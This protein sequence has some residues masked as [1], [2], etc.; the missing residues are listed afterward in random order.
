MR[1]NRKAFFDGY[2]SG[3]RHVFPRSAFPDAVDR[4][5]ADAVLSPQLRKARALSECDQD[6]LD[7]GNGERSGVYPLAPRRSLGM[8]IA[9]I[10]STSTRAAFSGHVPCVVEQRAN[11]Q[12]IRSHARR[13]IAMVTGRHARRDGI[14]L[15]HFPRNTVSVASSS[16]VLDAAV[17]VFVTVRRPDPARPKLGA[18]DWPVLIDLIPETIR[19]WYFRFSQDVNLLRLGFVLVRLDQALTRL[20]GPFAFYHRAYV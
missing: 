7:V 1:F 11:E 4:L 8:R 17:S 19:E 2:R 13:V 9:S 15:F 5:F 10:F 14:A 12:V 6:V 3:A 18:Y 16:V 20:F